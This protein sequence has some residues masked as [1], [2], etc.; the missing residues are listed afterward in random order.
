[1]SRAMLALCFAT[2]GT[3]SGEQNAGSQACAPCHRAIYESYRGTAM[4]LS[5]AP[6]G[7]GLA[8]ER[9]ERGAFTDAKSGYRYSV[10]SKNG[11]LSLEFDNSING[12]RGL[13]T[14][15]YAI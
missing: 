5:G 2:A 13:K 4:A 15:A 8:H 11:A 9:F 3:V 10:T 1:P 6:I 7:Q 12:I 14:L